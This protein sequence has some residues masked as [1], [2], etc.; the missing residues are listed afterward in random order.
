MLMAAPNPA[1]QEM[2]GQILG[3]F[4]TM[5]AGNSDEVV[6]AILQAVSNPNAPLRHFVG[7]DGKAWAKES[8]L[9]RLLAI[10][11]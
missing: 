7:G 8:L 3:G 6:Q 1:Y 9:T 5:V 4:G 10:G 2:R 11:P